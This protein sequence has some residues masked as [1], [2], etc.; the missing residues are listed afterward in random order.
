VAAAK[1]AR[2]GGART[3][4]PRTRARSAKR[5]ARRPAWASAL[6]TLLAFAILVGLGV[7]QLQRR[8]WKEHLLSRIAALQAAPPEPLSVVLNRVGDGGELD[9]VRVVA[10]CA[11][12]GSRVAHL[13]ALRP[14][15]AGS[16]GGPGW[17]Q[18]AVCKLAGDGPYGS[19]LVDAGFEPAAPMAPPAPQ[20]V[21]QARAGLAL[22]GVLRLPEPRPRYAGLLGLGARRTPQSQA[23]GQWFERDIPGVAAALGAERPAPAMLMLEGPRLSPRLAPSPLPTDIPNRHLEYALT[24]FGLA[25]TLLVFYAVTAL[26][27]RRR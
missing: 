20:P 10:P 23:S 4:P 18:L 24:W 26:R 22:T 5:A 7:W 21:A 15:T 16:E 11:A 9:F 12:L 17:R 1:A 19:I 27:G 14:E 8:V 13:Y 3:A 25:A 2:R 6:L